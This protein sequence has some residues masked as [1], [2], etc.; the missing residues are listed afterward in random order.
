MLHSSSL[1]RRSRTNLSALVVALSLLVVA[2]AFAKKKAAEDA[3]AAAPAASEAA[4]ADP[5]LVPPTPDTFG[6]VHFGPSSGS[7]LGRVN[8]K[9]PAGDNVKIFLEGRFF[10]TAPITIYSVPKGDYILEGTFPDGKT[11]S[12]PVSVLENDEAVIDLTGAHAAL[13]SPSKGG[14]MFSNKEMSESRMTAMKAFAIG[15]AAAL[16]MGI[17]FGILEK[18]KEN[19]YKT[20]PA[21][22]SQLDSISSTGKNYALL[23]N[24]GFALTFVGAI[25]AA[26]CAYPLFVKPSAEKPKAV[27]LS[28]PT[29]VVVPTQSGAAGSFALRF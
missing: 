28:K 8:V 21:N 27:A 3:P 19:D 9:A 25:G 11:V 1:A 22:Q 2:P 12:K 13:E 15:G 6:R 29:F 16:V 10:G 4:P 24:I 23:A 18:S 7:D 5:K 14:G 17:T 20:A 26:V